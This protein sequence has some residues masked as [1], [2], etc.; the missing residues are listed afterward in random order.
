MTKTVRG[1]SQ[2]YYSN[3]GGYYISLEADIGG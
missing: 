3:L 2:D 1:H